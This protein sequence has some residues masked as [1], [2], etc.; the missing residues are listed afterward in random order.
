MQEKIPRI[1]A[2]DVFERNCMFFSHDVFKNDLKDS[3]G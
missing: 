3:L 1:E 2:N